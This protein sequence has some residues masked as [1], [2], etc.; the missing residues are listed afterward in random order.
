VDDSGVYFGCDDGK[1]YGLDAIGTK[2]WEFYTGYNGT[3]PGWDFIYSSPCVSSDMVFAGSCRLRHSFYA[4]NKT[5]GA[6]IWNYT[7]MDANRPNSL[8][9]SKGYVYA[10]AGTKVYKLL[11]NVT[12]GNYQV[13]VVNIRNGVYDVSSEAS[14]FSMAGDKLF[15]SSWGACAT[16]ALN[17]TSALSLVWSYTFPNYVDAG[18]TVA[19]GRVFV[20]TWGSGLACFGEPFPPV[21]YYYT[22]SAGGADWNLALSINATPSS[23]LNS[24]QLISQKKLSYTLQ[25]IPGTTGMSN[26]SIPIGM[27]DGPFTSITVDGSPPIYSETTNNDTYS[28]IYLTY[29]HSVHTVEIVGTT[30]VPEFPTLT[31]FAIL[32]SATMMASAFA[33]HFRRRKPI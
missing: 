5:S 16:Y 21:T 33:Y 10:T 19:D 28:F 2:K 30:V 31:P 11:A 7:L 23:T 3:D 32:T 29:N 25:G 18:P 27:L 14:E 26:I 22:I 15:V 6:S 8:G 13:T 9:F 12:S 17:K 24:S 20:P 1:I 4:I